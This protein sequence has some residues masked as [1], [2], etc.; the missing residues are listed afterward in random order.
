[1]E[2]KNEETTLGV[3]TLPL[4]FAVL[5]DLTKSLFISLFGSLI[6]AIFAV[7]LYNRF[8][9]FLLLQKEKQIKQNIDKE[10]NN[11]FPKNNQEVDENKIDAVTKKLKG[12]YSS[13]KFGPQ[14]TI[15]TYFLQPTPASMEAS[16]KEM[17]P[18]VAAISRKREIIS[19][20]M[21]FEM[22]IARYFEGQGYAIRNTSKLPENSHYADMVLTQIDG[23]EL[24]IECK[25]KHEKP[26]VNRQIKQR[27]M[28]RW[29]SMG[30][31]LVGEKE[32]EDGYVL[33]GRKTNNKSTEEE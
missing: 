23:A 1:M 24:L 7:F 32:F 3:F 10:W 6:I 27:L 22:K 13:T 21:D 20:A 2:I 4:C 17:R 8:G 31:D 26:N 30:I 33:F 15:E 18:Q 5:W 14:M 16:L 9:L 12:E 28:R 11:Y 25:Y 29:G 19:R